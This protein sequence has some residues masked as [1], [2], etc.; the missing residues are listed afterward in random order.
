MSVTPSRPLVGDHPS[1]QQLVYGWV[2][3]AIL[4][5]RFEPGTRLVEQSLSKELGVSRSPLREALRRLEQEGLVR[6]APRRGVSVV[7]P[8]VRDVDDV[9]AIRAALEG[10]AA[11]LAAG[12]VDETAEVRLARILDRMERAIARGELK[13]AASADASFHAAIL[14]YG[15]NGRLVDLSSG[16]ADLVRRVRLAVLAQRGRAE[17]ALA[18]HREILE[19]LAHRDPARAERHMQSH[20]ARARDIMLRLLD[21]AANADDEVQEEMRERGK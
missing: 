15:G 14:E 4:S 5:G 18:E 17:A 13:L 16:L 21:R 2:K 9:Y 12:R 10:L 7:A 11:R 6:A 19:A 1:L 3:D 20:I 8:S